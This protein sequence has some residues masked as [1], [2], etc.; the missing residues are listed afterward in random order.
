[1]MCGKRVTPSFCRR[2]SSKSSFASLI[3]G[4]KLRVTC[5]GLVQRTMTRSRKFVASSWFRRLGHTDWL[6]C[7]TS[8]QTT[9]T[10]TIWSHWDGSTLNRTNDHSLHRKMLQCIRVSWPKTSHG[11]VKGPQL[12]R[13]P[14]RLVVARSRRTSSRPLD[15]NGATRTQ[16]WGRTRQATKLRIMK[17]CK[18]CFPTGFWAFSWFRRKAP[19]TTT[20]W[21]SSITKAW[22]TTSSWATRR[23]STTKCIAPITSCSLHRWKT[24][25]A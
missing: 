13:A 16:I 10:W 12:L 7:R 23:S 1:M 5:M 17:R 24:L 2:M 6:R 20:L 3:C 21:G 25:R 11:M 15:T 4:H 18:C 19:G 22:I 9:S 14:S 8:C